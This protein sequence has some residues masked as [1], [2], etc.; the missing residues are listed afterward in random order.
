MIGAI[1]PKLVSDLLLLVQ[2][3]E[4][5]IA[6]H[7]KLAGISNPAS[8]NDSASAR[9]LRARRNNLMATISRL[10]KNAGTTRH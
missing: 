10:E 8:Q 1:V 9:Q 6:F 4:T 2:Y 5:E 3:P 7:E